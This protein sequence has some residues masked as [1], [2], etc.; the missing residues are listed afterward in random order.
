MTGSVSLSD[1]VRLKAEALHRIAER[2]R[3]YSECIPAGMTVEVLEE[4]ARKVDESAA[5]LEEL[6]QMVDRWPEQ[7][8]V[9]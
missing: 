7:P 6:A 2:L 3:Y 5:S 9:E 1:G 4:Q 8:G